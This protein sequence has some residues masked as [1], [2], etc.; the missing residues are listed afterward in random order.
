MMINPPPFFE[1][2]LKSTNTLVMLFVLFSLSSAHFRWR[3]AAARKQGAVVCASKSAAVLNI[4][5]I[6]LSVPRK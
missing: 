3:G 6:L 2:A 5:V 4:T 1:I